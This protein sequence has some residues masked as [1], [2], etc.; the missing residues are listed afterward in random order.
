[1]EIKKKKKGKEQIKDPF[2]LFSLSSSF[3]SFTDGE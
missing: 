2:V 1:M 3:S